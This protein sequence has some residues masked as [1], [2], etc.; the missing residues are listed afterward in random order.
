MLPFFSLL[1]IYAFCFVNIFA[2][3]GQKL[4]PKPL[5]VAFLTQG[6]NPVLMLLPLWGKLAN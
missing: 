1:V 2:S 6:F 5:L 4:S 3:F